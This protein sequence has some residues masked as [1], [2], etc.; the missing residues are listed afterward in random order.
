MPNYQDAR[1]DLSDSVDARI[2]LIGIRTIEQ[3]RALRLAKETANEAKRANQTFLVYTRAKGLRDLRTNGVVSDDRSIAGAMDYAANLFASRQMCSI[4]FV[5]P[6][7]LSEDTSMA[8][9]F[10]ELARAADDNLCSLIVITDSPLWSGLSRLGMTITLDLPTTDEMFQTIDG[11]FRA[12]V[13]RVEILWSEED[14]RRASATLVGV[15]EAEAV[16]MLA[17]LLAPRIEHRRPLRPDDVTE[18]VGFKDSVFSDLAGLER[19]H[20]RE[21]E[22][23]VGGLENL[24]SWLEVN[25]TKVLRD[26]TG[27][28]FRPPRG[29]L[30]VGVP[31]CGKSLSAKTVAHDWQL[32]L[33]RLDL[34][35]VLGQYVGQSEGRLRQ[36]LETAE[37]VSPCVLWIDEI[38]KGLAGGSGDGDGG[39]TRRMVGQFLFWLQESRAKC[40]VVATAN[41]VR[42]LPPELLRKGRFDN[43]F[44]VDLPTEPERDEII[45]M[46]ITRYLGTSL[47]ED[48]VQRLVTITDGFAGSDLDAVLHGFGSTMYDQ[49]VTTID[50]DALERDFR[51]TRPLSRTNPEKIEEIRAWGRDR[52]MPAGRAI[53]HPVTEGGRGRILR[54]S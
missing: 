54:P 33:Y 26:W 39:T 17:R 27:T 52:A 19:V 20:L 36:A 46:Y 35:T 37:R 3:A 9:H 51:D 53:G 44:F 49:G 29:V 41:D 50:L 34:A 45:R 28:S 6:E 16:N 5:D 21:Q 18:L 31:G 22:L 8:R 25:R 48:F 1:R 10:A 12:H 40:F 14:A 11:L 15:T 38:E 4:V 23:G 32:P 42:A 47:A 24:R 7:E 2:P 43:M 13:G 30:L